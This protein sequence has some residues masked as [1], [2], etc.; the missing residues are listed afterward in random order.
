MRMQIG[1]IWNLVGRQC[2]KWI[3]KRRLLHRCRLLLLVTVD[4]MQ[5]VGAI[6]QNLD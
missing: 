4:I 5:V 2:E 1:V 6:R 3:D